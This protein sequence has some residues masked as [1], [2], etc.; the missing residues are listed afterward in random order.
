MK[1]GSLSI[2][3][4]PSKKVKRQKDGGIER[5]FFEL[6][7]SGNIFAPDAPVSTIIEGLLAPLIGPA[8]SLPDVLVV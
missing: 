5:E 1:R 7:D 2:S 8:Y 3:F 6:G 4:D